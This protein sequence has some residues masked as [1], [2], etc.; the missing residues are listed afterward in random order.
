V[1]R[2]F[3]EKPEGKRPLARPRRRWEDGITPDLGEIGCWSVDWIQLA[4]DRGRWRALVNAV[5]NHRELVT[6]RTA[7]N[8]YIQNTAQHIVKIAGTLGHI[9][10]I[11]L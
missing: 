2:V 7:Q 1:F 3:V 4:Q 9:T 8:P 6:V 10:T 5:M 11:R